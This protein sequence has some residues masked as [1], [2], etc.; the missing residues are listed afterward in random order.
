MKLIVSNHKMNLTLNEVKEYLKEIKTLKSE[1]NLLV[2]CP[3]FV[4]L[5][6]FKAIKYPLGSQNVASQKMG[7]L[8]GEI[9]IEQL[10]SLG[11]TY[12]IIGHSE[13]RMILKEDLNT[14]QKKISLCLKNDITPI[15]CIGEQQKERQSK[16]K[17][18]EQEIQT[19][20]ENQTKLEN[21]VIAYEPI[22]TIGTGLI[23]DKQEIE[24]TIHWIKFY[25][26][27]NYNIEC[28]VIYGGSVNQN[29]IL[30]LNKI[31]NMD[32]YLIGG[33]SLKI[34]ELKKI[35]EILEE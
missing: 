12:V 16:E 35:I 29:T 11:V 24:T 8:T 19:A 27:K 25:I 20:F 5:P 14:I 9:S 2:F 13:R 26:K 6:Y 3:S 21:I 4:Y 17:V 31:K 1:K 22:W 23:P 28:K 32:G 7:A 34:K 30:Q 18:L 33:T 10:K 15:L